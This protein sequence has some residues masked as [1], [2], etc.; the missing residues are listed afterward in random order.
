VVSEQVEVLFNDN[1]SEQ[2]TLLLAAAEDLGLDPGVVGTTEGAFVVPQE[3]HDKA[4]GSPEPEKK[5][6]KKS[7]TRK[8]V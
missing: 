3:V 4:F 1:P 7:T 2:A 8:K 5:T 6:A